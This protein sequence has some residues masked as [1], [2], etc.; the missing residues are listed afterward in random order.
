MRRF[1]KR[2]RKFISKILY[3]I[4]LFIIF[5]TII[6]FD[7]LAFVKNIP[8][9]PTT[10]VEMTDALVVL[11][12]GTKRLETGLKLLSESRAK[13]LFISGV[14]KGVDVRR[15][16][17]IFEQ[18]STKLYCCVE[19]GHAAESTEGN[20]IETREWI[21]KESYTSIRLV[22]SNYHM[23]RSIRLFSYHMPGIN[24]IPQPVFPD[25]FKGKNWWLWKGTSR[26]IILEYLKTLSF[27]IKQLGNNTMNFLSGGVTS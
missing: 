23:P 8:L 7:F 3:V 4:L 15:L 5:V 24:I 13:K 17:Q 6:A 12:G 20:A 22:T 21:K 26:L 9:T 10:N 25:S 19:L 1:K 11:T 18:N 27:R 14:Y 2:P 16:L